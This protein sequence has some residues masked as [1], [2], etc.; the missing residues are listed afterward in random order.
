MV[1][2]QEYLEKFTQL[3]TEVIAVSTD[4]E[5]KIL[6]S[7][8][9]LGVRFRLISDVERRVIGLFDVL[10][11]KQRIARP[12]TFIIDKRGRIRYRYI[13]KDYSDRPP[14]KGIMQVLSWM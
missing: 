10:H 6:K 14:I 1:Q 9:E 7:S 12:A 4:D 13:G 3:N 2:L 8:R 5:L 11:P